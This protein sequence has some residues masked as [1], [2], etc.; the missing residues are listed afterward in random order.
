MPQLVE[1]F[2]RESGVA[3]RVTYG[4]SGNFFTQIQNG[5]PFDLYF[6]ADEE[7]PARLVQ[8]G[9]ADGASLVT[10]AAGCLVVWTRR[11]AGVDISRGLASL[12]AP[13]IRR[14]AIA[15]PQHA[16]YGRAAVAALRHAGAYDAVRAKLVV[17]ENISQAAQFVQSG[18]AD[19]GILALSI[20]LAPAVKS[21]GTFVEVPDNAYPSIRQ[22]A[23][24][25]SRS[26]SQNE[27]QEFL[28]FIKRPEI[29]ALFR[30]FGFR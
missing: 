25:L 3:V 9:L 20:A 24:V 30:E 2:Q 27:A 18:N 5:A 7:Y 16:P 19:A 21:A 15:N 8:A 11:D 6:S 10:Y 13:Q 22:A 28:A 23:V 26:R 4:S 14:I 17:G 1:R 29:V 12:T